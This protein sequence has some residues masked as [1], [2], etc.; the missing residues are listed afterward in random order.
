M[1]RKPGDP[2]TPAGLDRAIHRA[3]G[4]GDVDDAWRLVGLRLKV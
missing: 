3:L 1:V 2:I 4:R